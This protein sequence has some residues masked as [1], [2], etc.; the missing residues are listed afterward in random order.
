MGTNL[1]TYFNNCQ[2]IHISV[3][4]SITITVQSQLSSLEAGKD[5]DVNFL[6]GFR[7]KFIKWDEG[8]THYF[9]EGIHAALSIMAVFSVISGLFLGLLGRGW[10][11]AWFLV[12]L[13]L[14]FALFPFIYLYRTS[15]KKQSVPPPPVKEPVKTFVPPQKKIEL[16]EATKKAIELEAALARKRILEAEARRQEALKKEE[17]RKE[18]AAREEAE[19]L[20][21]EKLKQKQKAAQKRYNEERKRAS[22]NESYFKQERFKEQ[23]STGGPVIT[24]EFFR[25][26]TNSAELKK[27]YL[28]LMKIYHPD[29]PSGDINITR[30]VQ[31]EYRELS[32]FYEAYEKHAR[33]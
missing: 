20:Y 10:I 33:R 25:G 26:V 22:F 15:R 21:R 8:L 6:K 17:E 19:R 28:D 2:I 23:S 31:A 3:I 29:N 13:G 11:A 27:R 9:G 4:I 14:L 7:G 32:A 24:S 5:A 18:Q 1:Q 12:L 30:R 16:D